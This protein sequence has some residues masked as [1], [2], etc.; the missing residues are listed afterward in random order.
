MKF[1]F[2]KTGSVSD[3]FYCFLKAEKLYDSLCDI[4]HKDNGSKNGL[5]QFCHGSVCSNKLGCGME[6]MINSLGFIANWDFYFFCNNCNSSQV[7]C[8]AFEVRDNEWYF[9]FAKSDEDV[10]K[11]MAKIAGA[12]IQTVIAPNS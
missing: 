3:A 4:L 5:A 12:A 7:I 10:V 9:F 8:Y 6:D 2:P 11:T 1:V